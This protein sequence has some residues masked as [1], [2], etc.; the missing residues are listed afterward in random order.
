MWTVMTIALVWGNE[1]RFTSLV[2]K[3]IGMWD[4]LVWLIGL[5]AST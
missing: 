4:H 2:E 5:S 3:I 1:V